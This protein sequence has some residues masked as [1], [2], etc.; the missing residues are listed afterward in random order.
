MLR[1]ITTTLALF[2]SAGA[3]LLVSMLVELVE[4]AEARPKV[5]SQ[6]EIPP[7]PA[8]PSSAAVRPVRLKIDFDNFEVNPQRLADRIHRRLAQGE[9]FRTVSAALIECGATPRSAPG[10]VEL[11][12][13]LLTD[14]SVE[15]VEVEDPELRSTAL[16]RCVSAIVANHRFSTQVHTMRVRVPLAPALAE[17]RR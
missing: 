14:G 5:A 12:I 11:S 15:D 1:P 9:A 4:R 13:R 10:G 16:G 17:P 7:V 2:G 8:P 3:L 6:P